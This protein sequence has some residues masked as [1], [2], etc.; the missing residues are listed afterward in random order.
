MKSNCFIPPKTDV[1]VQEVSPSAAVRYSNFRNGS[2]PWQRYKLVAGFG[3][4]A[5][6]KPTKKTKN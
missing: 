6:R 3:S 5:P 4:T 2:G 1:T